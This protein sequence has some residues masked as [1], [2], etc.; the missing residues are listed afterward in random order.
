MF[1]M[2]S[3]AII[4]LLEGMICLIPI[5]RI[6]STTLD[7][8]QDG[9]LIPLLTKKTYSPDDNKGYRAIAAYKDQFLAVGTDGRIDRI[10][11]SGETTPVTNTCMD[12]L[13]GVVYNN[14]QVIAVGNR[15]TILVSTDGLTCM[16]I[17]SGTEKNINTITSFNGFLIASADQGTILKN[18]FEN[19]WKSIQLPLKGDIVSISASASLC[20]GVTNKGEIIKTSDGLNWDIFDYNLEYKGYNKP[21]VFRK[22]LFTGGRIAVIGQHEDGSPVAL[23]SSLGNVWTERALNYS[24]DDGMMHTVTNL[25]NDICYDSAGDQFFLAFDHGEVVS[26]PSCSH[27]NKSLNVSENNLYGISYLENTLMLVGDDYFVT[28]VKLR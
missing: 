2:R 3:K 14:H 18:E 15:G 5:K 26:L 28:T 23:F 22:V 11:L 12:D 4:F 27:C 24:D 6:P 7:T 13:N 17:E 16:R 8:G 21:C 10:S 25:P 20:V 19:K 9:S 1:F